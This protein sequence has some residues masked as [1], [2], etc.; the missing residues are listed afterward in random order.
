MRK[1][2]CYKFKER[3][4]IRG[5]TLIETLIAVFIFTL[6]MGAA[7]GFIV[8]FYRTHSY[9][10]QQVTAIEE[11]RRG[12][13]TMVK[14]TRAA[15]TGDN[16]AYPV[17]RADDKQFI[18]YSDIDNDGQTERIRYFLSTIN[19]GSQAKEC[20]VTSQGGACNVSFSNFLTGT[21]KSALVS[22]SVMGDLDASDEYVAISADGTTLMS[23]LCQFGCL[24]CSGSY[25]GTTTFDVTSQASD[26][27]IQFTADGSSSVHR[28]CPVTSPNYSIKARF[29]LSWTEEVSGVGTE[30]KKGVIE[31]TGD[32]V[33]YPS[34]QEKI[35][36]ITRYV[37]NAPP[38]FKYFDSNGEEITSVP[39]R[40]ADTKL[41][42]V[43][44]VVNVDPN[45]PP[46]DFELESF[47]QL[48]NLKAE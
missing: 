15:R 7:T 37:R 45:R 42:K 46:K 48:R 29:E 39:A 35:S 1:P 10:S 14:E 40:L 5:F 9:A 2:I 31:P 47:V 8:V 11:A 34:S 18:F 21:L 27:S 22:L 3:K 13:E 16:G 44:L 36:I 4:P 43:Y 23:Q 20:T 28:Q 19:S 17:E 41:M 25:E 12:I 38:I 26:N 24:H 6:A 32:P 33:Q 30:L